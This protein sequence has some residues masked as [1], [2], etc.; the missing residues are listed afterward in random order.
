MARKFGQKE[1]FM[2]GIAGWVDFCENLYAKDK[3]MS[4][5]SDTLKERGP[6]AE[7]AF[8]SNEAF[9]VHRRL[10]VVDPENGKQPMERNSP[11]SK[12]IIVYNGE[13]YN[14]EK[15]R[16]KLLHAG[17][18]FS[19]H[20]DTEVLLLSY[21]EWG[22]K[23]LDELNGI[24]AFA[25][26]NDTEKTLFLARDRMGVKPL[27]FFEYENGLIFGSQIKTILAHPYANPVIDENGIAEI[28]LLGPAKIPGSGVFKGIHE[29]E[30]GEYAF[31]DKNGLKR[32][33]YWSL[34]PKPHKDNLEQTIEKTRFLLCD[35][36]SRQ[37]VSDVPLCTFL[38]G[39]LDSSIISYVA[40]KEYEKEGRKLS[41]YSIDYKGNEIYFKANSFQP[42]EDAPWAKLMSEFI[43][44]DHKNVLIDT[45]ELIQ[46][47][48]DATKARDL[49]GMA[50]VDSSLLLFCKEVKKEFTVA[51][52]GEC[53]DEIFGGY[54]WYHNK[55][56]LYSEGFPW[57]RSTEQRADLLRDGILKNINPFEFVNSHYQKTVAETLSND[58]DSPL[59]KRMKEMFMLNVKWFMQTLLDRK[60]RMSMANGLEVR[61]P[62]C[63]HEL[64]EYVFN[65]PWEIKSID[66]REKGLLRRC[67]KDILPDGIVF[68]KKNPYPK[69][70][71]PMYLKITK[72]ILT[73][74]CNNKDSRIFEILSREKVK[75]LLDCDAKS[76]GEPWFGQL[77][78]EAQIFAYLIQL[79][80]WL[81]IFDIKIQQ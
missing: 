70:F 38:S 14:T 27:F 11:S 4:K 30:Q 61:V 78:R 32:K 75:A 49:P 13:L 10:I 59:E 72:G 69:T 1:D 21:I 45:P 20:S 62:F 29:L 50:D 73:E 57:S 19:G 44:S 7:G 17:Y 18:S 25:V 51:V 48:H 79:E 64:A 66:G 77:M 23:C 81:R 5:M 56:I 22:E 34:S 16:K 8:K 28:M 2:C 9:L 6:D 67:F 80:F 76:F 60:D 42:D 46:A 31:F 37:L 3:I 41:T 74:I 40:A 24:Y 26:W 33:K 52:S 43:G 39:G 53:A 68:R 71:N 58:F 15:I 47:L 55:D 12:Y 54:P 35:S 36:I 65:I 63:D